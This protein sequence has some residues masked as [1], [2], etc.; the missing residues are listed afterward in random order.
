MG[1]LIVE[2]GASG[3]SLVPNNNAQRTLILGRAGTEEPV[4]FTVR[5]DFPWVLPP[6]HGARLM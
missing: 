2:E 6:M 1:G 5:E 3:F 4:L